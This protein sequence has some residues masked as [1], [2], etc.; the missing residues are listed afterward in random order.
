MG[1]DWLVP[2]AAA[3][4]NLMISASVLWRSHRDRT[5]WIFAGMMD[6][7]VAW[8]LCLFA[9]YYFPT[10]AEA[11]FWSRMARTGLCFAPVA[12]YHATL[13]IGAYEHRVWRILLVG[14]YVAATLVAIANLAG[15]LVTGVK[16]HQWGFYPE[17]TP[18]YGALTALIVGYLLL[19]VVLMTYGYRHPASARQR[20]QIK[21][22]CVAGLVQVPFGLTNLLPVY[23][24]EIYPLGSLGSV[25]YVSIIAYAIVRH[26]FMD[27]DYLVRKVVSFSLAAT[28][29]LG[30]GTVVVTLLA[31]RV[32]ANDPLLLGLTAAALALIAAVLV[33]TLQRALE[34]RIQRAFFPQRFDY[35]RR[36]RQF[37]TTLVHELD[38]GQLLRRLG[39]TLTEILD[40]E[41]SYVFARDEPGGHLAL[42]YPAPAS[43]QWLD[44]E[45]VDVLEPLRGPLLAGEMEAVS[46]A[47]AAVLQARRWEVVMPLRV[48]ERLIG[49]VALGPNKDMRIASAEDLQLL[50]TVAAGASVALENS[51]LSREL[52]RSEV[53]LQRASKLSSL[54][55][56]AAGIAHEIRNPLVAVKTFLDLLPSRLD[57]R[58][59]VLKFRELSQS[60]LRRVTDLISGL[61]ALGKSS[62][63]ERR[64]VDLESSLEPVLGLMETAARKREVQVI[65]DL[66]RGLPPIWADADQ[67]KQIV[68]NL[69][70]NAI[71]ASP[72]GRTV[73]LDGRASVAGTVVLEIRDEGCGISPENLE[74]IFEPFFTT[75]ESG[76]GLGLPL[77]HQM[78]VEHG[79][80]ITVES[81]IDRGTVFRVALPLADVA[82]LRPTGT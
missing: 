76:T 17:P 33:P 53:V 64:V 26:R 25:I 7:I 34:T 4:A 11:E 82:A 67:V 73:H 9:L 42:A 54:G 75:K 35:R 12:S 18:L 56:L 40:L 60:E 38:E 37:A 52:R 46:P 36:L 1:Y 27:L 19:S 71:E 81:E 77:V 32:E 23:G 48:N 49:L 14:G 13:S 20:V 51:R 47:A 45:L 29:V 65:V 72:E 58:E 61:L 62:T 50:A 16:P 28:V 3:V 57:D 55:T 8:N 74:S 44:D 2:L 70:L 22:L 78:V 15:L 6:C 5:S 79:G 80:E 39:D 69:L 41:H 31:G 24:I 66:E 21:F 43:T 63:A 30:P 68:L 10:P 59:F